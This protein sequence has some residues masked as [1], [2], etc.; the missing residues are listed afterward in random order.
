MIYLAIKLNKYLFDEAGGGVTKATIDIYHKYTNNSISSHFKTYT[1]F[2]NSIS[3][4]GSKRTDQSFVL[5]PTR[6]MCPSQ[7][8]GGHLGDR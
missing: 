1:M 6:T 5:T 2:N 8:G 3:E 4:Y 7:G